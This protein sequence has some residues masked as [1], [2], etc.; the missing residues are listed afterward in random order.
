M[1][2][3]MFKNNYMLSKFDSS[4]M[5]S[6]IDFHTNTT[7]VLYSFNEHFQ[8]NWRC[9]FIS[10]L[11]FNLCSRL[12][13]M[14]LWDSVAGEEMQWNGIHWFLRWW[15]LAIVQVLTGWEWTTCKIGLLLHVNL[16]EWDGWFG[17]S[18][19]TQSLKICFPHCAVTVEVELGSVMQWPEGRRCAGSMMCLHMPK[20]TYVVLSVSLSL[21][22]PCR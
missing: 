12:G 20:A 4:L 10:F 11:K 15:N 3:L 17:V 8:T 19:W 6:L 7:F 22:E 5:L 16:S 9:P 18:W 1:H 21:E 13:R 14:L 2:L